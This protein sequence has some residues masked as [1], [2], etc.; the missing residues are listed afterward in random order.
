MDKEEIKSHNS[1]S[2]LGAFLPTEE[3]KKDILDDIESQ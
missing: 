1:L 3:E 2:A